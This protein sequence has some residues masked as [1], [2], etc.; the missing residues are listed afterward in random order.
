MVERFTYHDEFV[1]PYA[2]EAWH[3]QAMQLVISIDET[4]SKRLAELNLP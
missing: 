4:P 3:E 1:C 2:D